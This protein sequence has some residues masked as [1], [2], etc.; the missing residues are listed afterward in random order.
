LVCLTIN[1][2]V[3]PPLETA[4]HV[5]YISSSSKASLFSTR[6]SLPAC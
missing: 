5:R 4:L 2:T 1:F 6:F 3:N